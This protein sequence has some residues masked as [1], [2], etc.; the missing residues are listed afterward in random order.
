MN[1]YAKIAE[2]KLRVLDSWR[3]ITGMS[4]TRQY[5]GSTYD[6]EAY[7]SVL[8]GIESTYQRRRAQILEEQIRGER[9][10]KGKELYRASRMP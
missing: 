1:K 8:S 6:V 2:K 7:E 4:V 5:S 10:L 9:G 3:N